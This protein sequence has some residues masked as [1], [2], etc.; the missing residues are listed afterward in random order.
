MISTPVV[1][2]PAGTEPQ[3]ATTRRCVQRSALSHSNSAHDGQSAA[4][5]QAVP[6]VPPSTRLHSDTVRHT[7]S[8][9]LHVVVSHSGAARHPD[10]W[11]AESN[12]APGGQP[13]SMG[14]TSAWATWLSVN[15]KP[16]AAHHTA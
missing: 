15:S 14:T 9:S 4:V 11:P 5:S 16:I 10:P 7:C 1:A 3:F 12:T 2:A 13:E 6:V 8:R